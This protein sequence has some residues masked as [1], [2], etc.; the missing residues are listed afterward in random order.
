MYKNQKQN[1]N[2]AI[3]NSQINHKDGEM[4]VISSILLDEV[5]SQ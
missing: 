1:A 4:K 3:E 5:K 2:K